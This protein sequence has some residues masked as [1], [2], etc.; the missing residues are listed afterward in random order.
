[1]SAKGPCVT[2]LCGLLA[3]LF[4]SCASYNRYPAGYVIASWYGAEF[5]GRPTSSG[6]IFDMNALTCAHREYAFGTKL[7]VTNMSNGKSVV[8]VVNDRGPFVPGRDIDLSFAAAR[9]IGLVGQGLGNVKI[10]YM[11]RDDSYLGDVRYLSDRGPL[12]IQI[13][14]FTDPSNASRLKS[15]LE[16]KYRGVYVTKTNINGQSFYRVRIGSFEGKEELQAIAR[17]LAEEGYHVFIARY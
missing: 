14:S 11:G 9:S 2:L 12:T 8:C 17:D 4:A 13:G 1:M 10:E 6:A 7:K 16:L 5:D 15:A 3:I